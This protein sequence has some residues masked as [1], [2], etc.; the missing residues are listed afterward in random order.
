M[1]TLTKDELGF[2]RTK[3]FSEVSSVDLAKL[4]QPTSDE[5]IYLS[6]IEKGVRSARP[7]GPNESYKAK[8]GDTLALGPRITKAA[9]IPERL[10]AEVKGLERAGYAGIGKPE[11]TAEGIRLRLKGVTLPG[12]IR[13][14]VLILLPLNYPMAC[15]IGFYVKKGANLGTIDTTH[16]YGDRTY[17]KAIDLSG[18]GWQWFCGVVKDWKPYRHTLLSYVM[19]ALSMFNERAPK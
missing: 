16:L 6:T 10:S 7:L 17:H 4:F 1:E 13:S 18:E 9:A 19:T 12:G 5:A 3:K 15:P 2:I 14:D 8:P 11:Q